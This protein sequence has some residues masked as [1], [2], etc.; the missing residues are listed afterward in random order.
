MGGTVF[1]VDA[2]IERLLLHCLDFE[3]ND[4]ILLNTKI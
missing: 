3:N 1:V 2:G 4:Y